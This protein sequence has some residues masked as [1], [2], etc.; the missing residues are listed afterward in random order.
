MPCL[1]RIF[2]PAVEKGIASSCEKGP[3]AG[4][5]VVGVHATLYDGS[6]HSVDSSEQAFKT[7]TEQCFKKGFMEANPILME[8]YVTLKVTVPDHYIGDIIGDLNKRRGSVMG[9]TP[10]NGKQV[11]EAEVPQMELFG[12]CTVL[13]SMTGGRGDFSYEFSRYAQ[14]PD[15]VQAKAISAY[16][17]ELASGENDE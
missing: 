7:A 3:L 16:Q 13:R 9:M 4:F 15:D 11:I 17:E 2:F 1:P 8:P 12:Y 10:T 14:A 6:F 5:P